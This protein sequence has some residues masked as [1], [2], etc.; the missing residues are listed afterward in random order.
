MRVGLT[1]G[2]GSGKSTAAAMF[3]AR[4]AHVLSAD[5]IARGLMA[6]GHDV[7]DQIV[8]QFGHSILLPDATLDRNALARLAFSG[9]RIEQ[10]NAI[11]HP[12]AIALQQQLSDSIL[13]S[14]PEAVVLVESA[15][16]FETKYGETLHGDGWRARF[17]R[18]ILVAATESHKIARFCK[19]SGGSPGGLLEAEARRR[20]SKMMPDEQ[21]IPLVEYV[22]HND[23]TLAELRTQVDAI[24]EQL[25]AANS[26]AFS[27]EP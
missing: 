8:Q 27:L 9:G 10:L 20:L 22:I 6:P 16:I 24:W 12:A 17:D 21:K 25:T 13:A 18:M 11:V 3:A 2:L 23:G 4:G 1:G 7:Y 15:L 14:D 5:E 26:P 19:R